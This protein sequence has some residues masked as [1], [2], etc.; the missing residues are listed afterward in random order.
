MNKGCEK[1]WGQEFPGCSN[2]NPKIPSQQIMS[3]NNYPKLLA[4]LKTQAMLPWED[5]LSII[6]TLVHE[7]AIDR[8]VDEMIK[9]REACDKQIREMEERNKNFIQPEHNEDHNPIRSRVP[10][11]GGIYETDNENI[12]KE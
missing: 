5:K 1:C 8:E 9:E 12:I 7:D 10:I 11:C 3:D 6:V 2:C 4:Y